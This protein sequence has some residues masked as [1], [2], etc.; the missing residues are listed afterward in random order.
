M[1]SR[2]LAP[3]RNG[4]FVAALALLLCPRPS[5]ANDYPTPVV[6]DY[7]I[8]CMASNG[9]TQEMMQ[10]CSCSID[11]ISSVLSYDTYEKA[12]TIMQMRLVAGDNTSMFR[13]MTMLKKV[14]DQLRLAQI[15][16]D[17]RCF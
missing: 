8:G 12:D 15:E 5:L 14:V 10:R 17:F 9:E 7:V 4:I 6:A 16:A 3:L 1:I 11:A 2:T 13:E